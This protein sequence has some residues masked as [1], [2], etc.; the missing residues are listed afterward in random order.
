MHFC[1]CFSTSRRCRCRSATI[2][3]M[4][5][6]RLP[7]RSFKNRALRLGAAESLASLPRRNGR[8]PW[9]RSDRSWRA[10]PRPGREG[11]PRPT[12]TTGNPRQPLTTAA[13]PAAAR[14]AATT[15]S[16]P[17]V[18]STATDLGANGTRR[19]INASSPAASRLGLNTSLRLKTTIS[20]GAR[21]V[22]PAGG[23]LSF[24]T[25]PLRQRR[26]TSRFLP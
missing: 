10:C 9:H 24:E 5:W 8:S 15:V 6:R 17:P 7:T 4:I 21:R 20:S 26:P 11:G 3:A 25:S 16:K 23:E 22:P 13:P 1:S 18:A 2:V 14:L 19:A 12:T